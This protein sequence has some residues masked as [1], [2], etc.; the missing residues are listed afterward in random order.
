MKKKFLAL[1]GLI[2]FSPF[3][4]VACQKNDFIKDK[5]TFVFKN[6]FAND[7]GSLGFL[8]PNYLSENINKINLA[9]SAKLFRIES[10]NQPE[11]D[12]RD[13]IILKP[14]ELNYSFEN[15][16]SI[17]VI[18]DNNLIA[19][20]NDEINL[21]DYDTQS[22][23]NPE[24]FSPK[25]DKGNGFNNPYIFIPSSNEKSI[26]NK[27]F[28]NDLKSSK[29]FSVSLSENENFWI[30]NNFN[31]KRMLKINDFRLGIF[32][33][34]LKSPRFRKDFNID[35]K[36]T[37]NALLFD[38]DS[39]YFLLKQNEIDINK[40]LDFNSDTLD[41]KT[42]NNKTLDLEN[43][44]LRLFI[45]TN[46][47]DALA[48]NIELKNKSLINIANELIKLDQNQ[49]NWFA[50]YYVIKQNKPELISLQK[51]PFYKYKDTFNDLEKID[52]QY[53]TIPL[54]NEA[55]ANQIFYAFKQNIISELAF[56]KLS[57]IEK[58]QILNDYEKY[59]I[60]YEREVNRTFLNNKIILNL[61]PDF[62]NGFF[63]E[64]FAILYY[65]LKYKSDN[66]LDWNN[67][68]NKK[69]LA[70]QSLFNN[71]ANLA[72][73]NE[74][75]AL[76]LSQAPKDIY[77]KN[78]Q[79]RLNYNT[80]KDAYENVFKKNYLTI[81]NNEISI[82]TKHNKKIEASLKENLKA[83]DFEDIKNNLNALI[84]DFYNQSNSKDDIKVTIPVFLF[85]ATNQQIQKLDIIKNLFLEINPKLKVDFKIVK[86]YEEFNL[87]FKQNKSI[88][89]FNDFSLNSPDTFDF[90]KNEILLENS[91][92]FTLISLKQNDENFQR[93]FPSLIALIKSL[94]LEIPNE[95]KNEPK[96]YK[97]YLFSNKF[98]LEN[99]I[100]TYLK[101][102]SVEKQL[103]L[104]KEINQLISQIYS[105]DNFI[106]LNSF[107]KVVYQNHFIKPISYD[108]LYYLQDIKIK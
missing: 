27:S 103:S 84:N 50:S 39:L 88:Y 94:Q 19:Y 15:A 77:L 25:K 54:P 43:L 11:I 108:G 14:T 49:L 70:F 80:L 105:F 83:A 99:K 102:S 98:E 9:T 61:L 71:V 12:F 5:R 60:S 66:Q 24:I 7:W 17:S 35:I 106:N 51:N 63:N 76:W 40:L 104:I 96:S 86:N 67:L 107:D 59:N 44:F 47:S 36:T 1:F 69:A 100:L 20:D 13:N 4:V 93:I 64:N 68:Y 34:L 48:N 75:K 42:L 56:N 57:L 10:N 101:N 37:N 79:N 18:K 32:R 52:F 78:N 41:I 21:V 90:I 3:L 8:L 33:N 55:F 72:F 30:D 82:K 46:F 38:D 53:S 31:K 74:D 2:S 87:Y 92:I 16:S 29:G 62:E 26:N 73:L 23:N 81:E 45:Q 58:E 6:N 95:Q 85:E 97:N 22:S 91:N 65:G 89:K 28:F